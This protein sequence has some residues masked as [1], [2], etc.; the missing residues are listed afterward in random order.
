M[1][2]H[3]TVLNLEITARKERKK[4]RGKLNV[5]HAAVSD[6]FITAKWL[7][8]FNVIIL[9]MEHKDIYINSPYALCTSAIIKLF[10]RQ[11]L[12]TKVMFRVSHRF[13]TRLL[14]EIKYV[15]PY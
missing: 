1:E 6:C 9:C 11:C 13:V 5:K 7:I 14:S 10:Q 4:N 2:R 15:M 8:A 12:I 3:K